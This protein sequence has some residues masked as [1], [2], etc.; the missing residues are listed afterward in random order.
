MLLACDDVDVSDASPLALQGHAS[1][2]KS[3]QFRRREPTAAS[4]GQQRLRRTFGGRQR[5][6]VPQIVA[7]AHGAGLRLMAWLQSPF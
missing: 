2:C 3:Q 1:A 5:L 7:L 6:E 4:A